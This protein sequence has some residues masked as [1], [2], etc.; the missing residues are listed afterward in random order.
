MP[1]GVSLSCANPVCG[2]PFEKAKNEYNRRKRLGQ[3][4]F[5]CTQSC[6]MVVSNQ[7]SPRQG[8]ASR[9]IAGNRRDE[10][11][12]FRWFV[13]RARQRAYK[14]GPTNLTPSYLKELWEKQGGICPFTRWALLLPDS[15]N[16]WKNGAHPKNASLDRIN[17][18]R[19][20]VQGNVRFVSVMANAARG[21]FSDEALR[22]FC[23]AV[24]LMDEDASDCAIAKQR[25]DEIAHEPEKLVRGKTLKRALARLGA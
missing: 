5:Y 8:D 19:G 22:Q 24:A 11:T 2:R 16:G 4:A 6:Q 15:T 18:D 10:C 25:L 21:Q 3:D 17:N 9:L 20:Y 7:L 23:R 1:S 12:P 14:K 13:L